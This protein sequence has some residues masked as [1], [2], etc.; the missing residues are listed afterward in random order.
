MQMRSSNLRPVRGRSIVAAAL[1]ASA[2]LL[3]SASQALAQAR[4]GYINIEGP[5]LERE[6]AASLFF[7]GS[8]KEV[9]SR[10]VVAALHE[11]AQR[12]DLEGV[13]LRLTVPQLTG[14][15][16]DEL[17]QAMTSVRETGKKVHVF[18]E[19]YS[20]PLLR[21]GSFA[22]EVIVQSG[23]GVFVHGMYMENMFLADAL[24]NLGLKFDRVMVGDFKGAMEEL[25]LSEPSDAY[26]QMLDSLLDGMYNATTSQITKG[27]NITLAQLEKAMESGFLGDP[28]FGIQHKLVDASIDRLALRDHLEENY[29]E[30]VRFI[31]SLGSLKGDEGPDF[32][33]MGFFESF[34]YFSNLFSGAATAATPTRD[35]IAILH[36]DGAIMDGKSSSGGLFGGN[37]VGSLTIRQ[38]TKEIQDDANI[39]GVIVRI[40]SPGGSAIA[41]ESIWLGLRELAQHKPV[42]I[43]VGNMAASGGYYIAVAGDRIYANP[44]SIVGSIGVVG[45]KMTMAGLYE[46][47]DVNIVSRQR[48][49]GGDIFSGARSWT[50]DQRAKI[51]D[52]M[53]KIYNLFLDRVRSGRPDID[54]SKTAAGRLFVGKQALDLNM[55]DKIAGINTAI[56]DLADNL[57]LAQGTFDVMDY[58]RPKSFDELLEGMFPFASAPNV[59]QQLGTQMLASGLDAAF[60]ELFGPQAWSQ[61]RDSMNAMQTFRTQ[62]VGVVCPTAIIF[63]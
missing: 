23:G 55:V 46:K 10:A 1:L 16:I 29:G 36:I 17:G 11:V 48:G 2:A 39:K 7:G 12:G 51:A 53:A 3:S 38:T 25:T 15:Q 43:S 8:S 14:A 20:T 44:H 19:I 18:T 47:F 6:P 21:L 61:V 49:P 34:T 24:S 9:T 40:D 35:T 33:K 56:T 26:N 37:S 30:S 32:A 52:S 58:P 41:S 63:R 50:P 5:L 4:L 45:G 60:T 31:T 27:R 54:T 28:D 22:D 13:V 59:S 42:W 57:S 62:P